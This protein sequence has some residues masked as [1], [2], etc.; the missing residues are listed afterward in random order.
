ME[1][2]EYNYIKLYLDY[3]E[4]KRIE[5]NSIVSE[6]NDNARFWNWIEGQLRDAFLIGTL[7]VQ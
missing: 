2:E 1:I 4:E 6:L 7:C 5:I 3:L